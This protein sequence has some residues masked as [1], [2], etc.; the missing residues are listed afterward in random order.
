[1]VAAAL[2]LGLA[3]SPVRAQSAADVAAAR[4]LFIEGSELSKEGQWEHARDRFERSLALKRSAITLYSLGV[5]QMNIGQH[6]EALESFRAFL[7]YP[8][9][10]TAEPYVGPA[11]TAIERLERRVAKLDIRIEPRGIAGL[12][13][14][15]D[16]VAIPPAALGVPRLVNAGKHI[17]R[18]EAPGY[19]SATTAVT[20]AEA[21]TAPVVLRLTQSGQAGG[22]S[23][24][25]L[26][27]PRGP[28]PRDGGEQAPSDFPVGP[29]TLMIGGGV[30]FGVG[31]AVGLVGVAEAGDAPSADSPEAD[32]AKTKAIAGDVVAGVGVA[33]AAA[34][35]IWLLVDD[36]EPE[37]SAWVPR[38]LSQGGAAGLRWSF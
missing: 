27:A 28:H 35:L 24:P 12:T 5:A 23:D 36:G 7:A 37:A 33:A 29:V 15:V 11:E 14:M 17:I 3:P 9:S 13:V 22:L 30:V 6:V 2:M 31:L 16:R 20:V 21:Q 34:G 26:P 1:M 25:M 8:E 10:E 18:A 4:E 19:G 38:P 32:S